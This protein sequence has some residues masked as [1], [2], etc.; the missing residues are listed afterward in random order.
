MKNNTKSKKPLMFRFVKWIVY[1]ILPKFKLEGLEN[2][3]SEECIIVSNHAQANAPGGFEI[4]M[5]EPFSIWCTGEMMNKDEVVEYSYKDFFGYKPK[6]IRWFF[7]FLCIIF[8][9][10]FLLIFTNAHTI[11]V[12]F[13]ARSLATFRKSVNLMLQHYK[14]IITPETYD[15]YNNI[16]NSYRS[17][18]IDLGRLYYSKAKKDI[19]FVPCYV[20]PALKRFYF[21]KPIYYNSN[22]D[23]ALERERITKYLMEETTNIAKNLP[24]HKVTPYENVPKRKYLYNTPVYEIT[25]QTNPFKKK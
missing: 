14:I 13:D 17:N 6:F 15:K 21:G 1:L 8:K 16:I 10:L 24:K 23:P 20:C 18:Y 19:S 11:P 7:K 3:P 4:Y 22:N 9:P 12:Y 5:D 25:N 2:L